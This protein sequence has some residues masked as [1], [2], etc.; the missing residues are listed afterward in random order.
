VP[1]RDDTCKGCTDSRLRKRGVD[2]TIDQVLDI[3][4]PSRVDWRRTKSTKLDEKVEWYCRQLDSITDDLL[5]ER[6]VFDARH[7]VYAP[8][9]E[10]HVRGGGVT[11]PVET[12]RRSWERSRAN[13]SMRRLA[14][15]ATAVAGNNLRFTLAGRP[16]G[17]RTS[18]PGEEAPS[19]QAKVSAT[20]APAVRLALAT[21]FGEEFLERAH[22]DLVSSFERSG[23]TWADLIV[24]LWRLR[25][26]GGPEAPQTR[27]QRSNGSSPVPSGLSARPR[28]WVD[29][30]PPA[31]PTPP[32]PAR[33][34]APQFAMPTPATP[35]YAQAALEVFDPA[36]DELATRYAARP[37]TREEV[38]AFL[39]ELLVEK[40]GYP[41][42]TFE[43]DLDLEVDLGIDTVKQVEVLAAVRQAFQ[44]SVDE[45]FRMRDYNTLGAATDYIAGRLE[46]ESQ[47]GS[48][49]ERE[50]AEEP[51]ADL[52][53]L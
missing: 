11:A 49:G 27:K 33:P 52:A 42:E 46:L 25:T 51:D 16:P 26:D 47:P 28:A 6:L 3:A 19:M 8:V 36:V 22:P 43:D 29:A 17:E 41:P 21:L 1:Y 35:A 32:Q 15:D 23:S 48:S 38:R 45:N 50:E 4:T 24:A 10:G 37:G 39:V 2:T 44:L 20:A 34:R 18:T 31:R 9:C 14:V 7:S 53:T 13:A 40:T 30:E 5:E 12:L